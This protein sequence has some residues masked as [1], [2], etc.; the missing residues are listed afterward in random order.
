MGR[1]VPTQQKAAGLD[2]G[3]RWSISHCVIRQEKNTFLLFEASVGLGFAML[4]AAMLACL[5]FSPTTEARSKHRQMTVEVAAGSEDCF[6][7]PE[8]RAGQSIELE[9]QVTSS[10]SAT[11][12]NDI[13]ARIFSPPPTLSV[14]YETELQNDGSFNGEAEENGDYKVCFDNRVSTFSDKIVWFEVNVEDPDDDYT[15]DD[16]YFDPEDWDKMV[17]NNEDTQSLFEMKVGKMRHFQF[18]KGGSMSKD[19][20]QVESNLSRLNFWSLAHLLLMLIVG[21]SQVYMV[22]QLFDEKSMVQKMT[23]RA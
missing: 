22:R 14:M 8:V 15:D 3:T 4:V 5:L 13:T 7:L 23:A 16:D 2:S 18:M 11:G 9:F 12:K 1:I 17:D 19:T 6:F 21:V 20:H 10:S